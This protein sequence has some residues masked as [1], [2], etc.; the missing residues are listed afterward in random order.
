M[1]NKLKFTVR[2]LLAGAALAVAS[3]EASAAG[4]VT[5]S[6]TWL[7][8][9]NVLSANETIST[10]AMSLADTAGGRAGWTGNS[11]LNFSA[12][13]HAVRW[14]SFQVAAAN[15]TV[16]ITDSVTSGNRDLAF[17]VWASNGAFDGGTGSGDVSNSSTDPHS[18]NVVGQLG[19]AGTNW[20]HGLNGNALA[21]L[22]YVNMGGAYGSGVTDWGE[23][24]GSGVN[25]V[26]NSGLYFSALSGSTGLGFAQ[27]IFQ[28]LAPGWYTVAAGGA[29]NALTG[30]AGQQ[31]AVSTVPVPAAVYLLGSAL[32]GMG[33]IG[34]R[35][36]RQAA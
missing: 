15:Q 3:C 25:Q 19:D 12:W 8:G 35:R 22:A 23:T 34:R 1:N 21:T 36:E 9:D 14:L 18:T 5:V 26:D 10:S 32:A 29:N 11:A 27:L 16:Y 30:V 20:M 4:A 7:G 31:L 13:G 33:I 17:T 2:S 6:N 28:N 24:I